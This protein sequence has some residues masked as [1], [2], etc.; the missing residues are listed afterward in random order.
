MKNENENEI[1]T[2]TDKVL[3][4]AGARAAVDFLESGGKAMPAV[5]LSRR[6]MSALRGGLP[7]PSICNIAWKLYE[8]AVMHGSDADVEL[9]TQ[10]ARNCGYDMI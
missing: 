10:I 8:G 1:Q 7:F 4:T 9:T 6:E 2:I 3:R 5:K